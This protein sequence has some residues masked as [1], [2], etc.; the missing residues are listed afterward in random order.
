MGWVRM[1]LMFI[2]EGAEGRDALRSASR[3]SGGIEV[4]KISLQRK[5]RVSG[6]KGVGKFWGS[7][8]EKLAKEIRE[9]ELE[10]SIVV[11]RSGYRGLR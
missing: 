6:V 7:K 11:D 1:P 4:L 9:D 2:A 3:R 10:E 5:T 8:L